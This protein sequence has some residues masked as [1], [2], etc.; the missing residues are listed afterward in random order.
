MISLDKSLC[1]DLEAAL[2]REW[3]ETNGLGGFACGTVAGA[4]TRRYHGLLTA[5]LNPP[6]GRMLLLSKLEE[7]LVVGDQRIDLSTN[8]YGGAVHPRG[9]QYLTRFCQDPFPAW[10]IEVDGIKLKKTVFMPHGSNTVQVEYRATQIPSG[11]E[12]TLEVRPLIAFRDY[13]STT[14]ENGALH[15]EFA[16][17]QERVTVQPY[18]T[19]PALHFAHDAGRVEKEGHWYRDFLFRIERERGLDNREDLFNPLVF[20]W[21][22]KKGSS[23]VVIAS[24]EKRN[25]RMAAAVRKAELQRRRALVA[26][27]PVDDPLAQA[28]TLVADQ[29]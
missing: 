1:N 24:T 7:T 13:H 26:N 27:S 4:N 14:H 9:Y 3:L 5:A 10:T 17:E 22:L 16:A 2:S 6:G 23:A 18:A 25:V 15:Q 21:T 11:Q 20:S 29:Y 19:L 12:I 28:L 8:E